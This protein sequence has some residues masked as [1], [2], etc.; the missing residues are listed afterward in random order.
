[1]LD[2]LENFKLVKNWYKIKLLLKLVLNTLRLTLTKCHHNFYLIFSYILNSKLLKN[3]FQ[4]FCLN[5]N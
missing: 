1:M 5:K 4:I 3:Q 2:W